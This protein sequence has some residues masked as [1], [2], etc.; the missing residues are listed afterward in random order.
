MNDQ[1]IPRYTR[2]PGAAGYGIYL[3]FW[4]G[5]GGMAAS[6]KKR[7]KPETAKE[8]EDQLLGIIP[9]EKQKLISVCVIDV[10]AGQERS[11]KL[12]PRK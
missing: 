6:H 7:T 8:L 2:D 4:F 12:R 9:L 3:V 1:L 11:A 5:L 10:G